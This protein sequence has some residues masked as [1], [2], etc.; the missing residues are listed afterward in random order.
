M[1]EAGVRHFL[2]DL[3]APFDRAVLRR[4]AKD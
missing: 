1:A 3:S 2:L 4:F